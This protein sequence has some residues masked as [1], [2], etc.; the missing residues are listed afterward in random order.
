[1]QAL[2]IRVFTKQLQLPPYERIEFVRA[3]ISQG[4]L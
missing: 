1:L 2:S 3:G 4:E